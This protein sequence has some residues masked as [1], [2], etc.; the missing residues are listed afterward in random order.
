VNEIA[1]A[2]FWINQRN[3]FNRNFIILPQPND[4]KELFDKI[5]SIVDAAQPIVIKRN[6]IET[7]LTKV[8]F[9][10]ELEENCPFLSSLYQ[11]LEVEIS[12][13]NLIIN[14]IDHFPY[15]ERYHFERGSEKAVID[16][17]Y[18]KQGVFGRVVPLESGS[19][20]AE[21][22]SEIKSSVEK[23]KTSGYVI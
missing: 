2:K 17:E 16:F 20:S 4:S 13:K 12:G 18:D 10:V 5:K 1:A 7:V 22:M 6:R 19:N 23:L 14:K 8:L 15:R 3:V 11:A 21:L 9:E